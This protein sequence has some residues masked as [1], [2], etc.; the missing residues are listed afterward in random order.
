MDF[1]LLRETRYRYRNN[2][3]DTRDGPPDTYNHARVRPDGAVVRLHDGIDIYADE[4]EPFAAVFAGTVVDPSAMWQPWERERYGRVVVIVSDEPQTMGY[5]AL[6]AHASR[7]WVEPGQQVVRGQ[8]LGAVGRTGN[9]EMQSIHPHLHFELRAPFP[10]DWASLGEARQV[11]AFNPYPS[12][13]TADPR[14]R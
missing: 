12:L 7:V 2:F 11:D 9:A 3:L 13:R 10:L 6:Y 1:P 4:G 8:V 14:R 5:I